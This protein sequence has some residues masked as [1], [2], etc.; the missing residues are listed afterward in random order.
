MGR[1]SSGHSLLLRPT[2]YQVVSNREQQHNAVL[3]AK[4]MVSAEGIESAL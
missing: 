3:I 1:I 4:G 2:W